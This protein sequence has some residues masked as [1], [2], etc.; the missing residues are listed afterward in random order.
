[1]LSALKAFKN[2]LLPWLF[3]YAHA[4][5]GEF[6]LYDNSRI[7]TGKYKE[8][9]PRLEDIFG[10]GDLDKNGKRLRGTAKGTNDALLK[11]PFSPQSLYSSFHYGL[12][13]LAQVELRLKEFPS[14]VEEV[15]PEVAGIVHLQDFIKSR[16]A[17]VQEWERKHDKERIY[18]ID[19]SASNVPIRHNSRWL[20]R[21]VLVVVI[22]MD[23]NIKKLEAK[24]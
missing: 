13:I 10:I 17:E 24:L 11:H 7:R 19:S 5:S 8:D 2:L 22:A 9:I 21:L 12:R 6:G 23:K 3:N 18:V 4:L 15:D 1:M 14:F 16:I 20:G